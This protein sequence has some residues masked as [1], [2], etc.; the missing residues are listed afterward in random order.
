MDSHAMHSISELFSRSS[1]KT[2]CSQIDFSVLTV[3]VLDLK[4]D[5]KYWVGTHETMA[6]LCIAS[7]C[8]CSMSVMQKSRWNGVK[9]V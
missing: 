4:R 5:N 1:I 7:A 3:V 8:K 9:D 2:K 6:S